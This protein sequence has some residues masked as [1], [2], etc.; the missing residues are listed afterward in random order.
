[1]EARFVS[2]TSTRNTENVPILVKFLI[3]V[4]QE[5]KKE[6]FDLSKDPQW[7]NKCHLFQLKSP[8]EIYKEIY[9]Q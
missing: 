1:L 3:K 6:A 9:V 5:F 7:S 8:I 2:F 4:I